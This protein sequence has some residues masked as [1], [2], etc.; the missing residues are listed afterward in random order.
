MLSGKSYYLSEI[1]YR[2]ETDD[3][4][5]NKKNPYP[6]ICEQICYTLLKSILCDYHLH[7]GPV[8]LAW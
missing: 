7:D 6:V 4:S 3:E 8:S 5:P 2:T 1:L